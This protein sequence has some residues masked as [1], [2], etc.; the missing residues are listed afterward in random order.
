MAIFTPHLEILPAPQKALWQ[1]LRETP[2]HFTLYGGTALALRIGHRKSVDF[3]FFSSQPF[4]VERLELSVP[5]LRGAK[6]KM[7]DTNTLISTVDRGGEV[8]VCFFGGRPIQQVGLRE[9]PNGAGFWV[10]SLIDIAATKATAI[11]H[12]AADR[13]YVD[14]D[15]LI[16][17]GI[18]LPSILAAAKTV[19]GKTFNPLLTLKALSYYG[20]N[21]LLPDEVK[22]R[23]RAAVE[24]VDITGLPTFKAMPGHSL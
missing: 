5:Y 15:A 10:A 2:E 18:S 22:K 11:Q 19:W 13:D 24:A 17:H 4:D 1:E 3:D 8:K 9:Q 21:P 7:T 6:R 23:L 12:R 16:Q 20:D 14:F